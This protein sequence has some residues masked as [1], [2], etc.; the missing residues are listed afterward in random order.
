MIGEPILNEGVMPVSANWFLQRD[1]NSY[2]PYSWEQFQEYSREGRITRDDLVKSEQMIQWSR[3]ADVPGLFSSPPPPPSH[4]KTPG[5]PVSAAGMKYVSV[6]LR[7]VALIID[8]AVFFVLGFIIALFTGDTTSAG[9]A[10][11]G[12][13]V[14]FQ[15]FL[16]M[17][18]YLLMEGML[19]ATLGKMAVGITVRKPDG[20]ICGIGPALIRNI[21]RM[22]DFLPFF[23]LLGAILIWVSP[24]RQ[25]LGDRVAG[26]V[27]VKK[28]GLS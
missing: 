16:G 26:T 11:E 13:P 7:F 4:G 8:S 9:Y 19:G 20:S 28:S 27:V 24:Q 14:F 15:F 5:Q 23:Y 18:Y 22:V 1:G 10:M 25:R 6:G 12:G 3:A 17:A 21:L 2:G